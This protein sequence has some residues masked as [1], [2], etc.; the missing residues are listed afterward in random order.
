MTS[1]Y[2]RPKITVSRATKE[3]S[4]E[5]FISNIFVTGKELNKI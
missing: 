2:M 1:L 5:E 3:T 4:F